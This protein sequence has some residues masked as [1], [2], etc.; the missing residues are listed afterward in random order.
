MP[1]QQFYV[2][3]KQDST[4]CFWVYCLCSVSHVSVSQCVWVG[5][6]QSCRFR[7]RENG[8][9]SA[10]K[11]GTTGWAELP[12]S[13][14]D[15]PGYSNASFISAVS[16]CQAEMIHFLF[17]SFFCLVHF[18]VLDGLLKSGSLLQRWW[19]SGPV[20]HLTRLNYVQLKYS[21]T[22]TATD[23]ETVWDVFSLLSCGRW[24]ETSMNT[25]TS[26]IPRHCMSKNI[27]TSS[28][29]KSYSVCVQHH[30]Q[31]TSLQNKARREGSLTWWKACYLEPSP[32]K[33]RGF[34]ASCLFWRS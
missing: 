9:Q 23:L 19:T 29:K 26:Q 33:E 2:L 14:L 1:E 12:V 5:G 11:T 16:R 25:V 32:L 21:S 20:V 22:V 15:T 17:V 27:N 28:I 3:K 31:L 30:L 13:S 24:D 4:L 18:L 34:S 7:S 10:Q 6:V 8:G